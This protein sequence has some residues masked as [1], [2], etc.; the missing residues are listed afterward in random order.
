MKRLLTLVFAVIF[1]AV[2]VNAAFEKVNTYSNNFS[3]VKDTNWFSENVK[4]A[5]ELGFMNGK[6]EGKFDPNGNVTVA[7]GVTMAARVHA[8]YNGV[9]LDTWKKSVEE[10]RFDFD[11]LEYVFFNQAEGEIE[12]GVL[13]VTATELENGRFDPGVLFSYPAFDARS[14][15]NIKVRMKIDYSDYPD[16]KRQ[17]V[18][19]VYFKTT[20]EP[21]WS[22]K[23]L[24]YGRLNII[25]DVTEWF[26]LEIEMGNNAQWSDDIIVFRFDPSNDPG[27]YYIDSVV[28]SKSAQQEYNKWYD[29]YV[30][31]AVENDI[32]SAGMFAPEDYNRNITRA[33]LTKLFAAS[34]PEESFAPINNINGIPDVKHDD[35]NADVILALYKA[36]IVLGDAKGN[37][38]PDADIKRSEVAAIINRLA[39]P[40]NRV[41]GSVDADWGKNNLFVGY[42]FSD[43]SY[44][45]DLE[46]TTVEKVKI[47]DGKV[48]FVTV[49]N[50]GGKVQYDPMITDSSANINADKYT[51]LVVRMKPEFVGAPADPMFDF[52]F[53]P[54]GQERFTEI[55]S[56]HQR[57]NEFCYV[58][59]FGWYIVEVD[60]TLNAY[61]KGNVHAFRFDPANENGTYY[62][63]YIRFVDEKGIADTSHE[64]LTNSGYVATKMVED[65]TFERG[66]YVSKFDQSKMY[67]EHGTWQDYASKDK[68]PVWGICP[69]WQTY[70]LFENRD[71]SNDKYTLSDDKGINLI[72]YNP[73]SKSITMRLNATKIYEGKPHT[74]EFKL[75]PHLLLDQHPDICEVDKVKN[76]LGGA[77][78]IFVEYDARMLDFKGTTNTEGQN[79]CLF[80][81]YYYLQ[82][83]KE[84]GKKIWFGITVFED[85][86]YEVTG[87]DWNH[88]PYSNMM[89]YRV[90]TASVYGG[91]EKSFTPE[92]GLVK[93]GKDWK[94]MR[95]DVTSEIARAIEWA[96]RDN[97]FG[98]PVT[99]DDMYIGGV[100]VG[101]EI[102]GNFDATFELKNFNMIKYSKPE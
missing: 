5:Y 23:R 57:L 1:L 35:D 88:D 24:V 85:D 96:N 13:V 49:E 10:I 17:A 47:N 102:H 20:T 29:K 41:K 99:L 11:D 2:G 38:S 91:L 83:D 12:D 100:N 4:T 74:D 14:Y 82:T 34:M 97:T 32:I 21:T 39:L 31:Y 40:E 48:S 70:D 9:N 64:A 46:Y 93:F 19:E 45:K 72:K 76:S 71:K 15:S 7:E 89:I 101:Y 28:L 62:V 63:D 18:S 90:V 26:D 58:D 84:P 56:M 52:F 54:E 75:W 8:I 81:I 68:A 78:K 80:V 43:N 66:F 22:E 42:E 92:P 77:E 69:W 25:E 87:A 36:G 37:F 16:T 61:W 67:G 3:D 27:T 30:D 53:K 79:D 94:N 55:C 98:V 86:A 50:I 6:S 44:L 65:D 60:L 51:K 33:E 73:E 95:I 59:A